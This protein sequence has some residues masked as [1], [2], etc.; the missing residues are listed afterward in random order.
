MYILKSFVCFR[1]IICYKTLC[2]GLF[3]SILIFIIT[4]SLWISLCIAT[5]GFSLSLI[6]HLTINASR[7]ILI[8]LL[9]WLIVIILLLNHGLE[10][11]ILFI[12]HFIMTPQSIFWLWSGT[13]LMYF[14]F[15]FFLTLNKLNSIFWK[16][17]LNYKIFNL[18]IIL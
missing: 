17:I 2:L 16:W 12:S 3:F 13:W 7:N 14:F 6:F 15:W 4:K 18:L 9:A 11:W 10:L 8:V 5:I 1:I